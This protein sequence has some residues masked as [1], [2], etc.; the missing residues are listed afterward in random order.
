MTVKV[1]V[2][3]NRETPIIITDPQDKSKTTLDYIEA[4]EKMM[5]DSNFMRDAIRMHLHR[6]PSKSFAVYRKP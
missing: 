3:I 2:I 5:K 1:M 4:G 6:K